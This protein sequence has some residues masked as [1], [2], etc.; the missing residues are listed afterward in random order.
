ML[1]YVVMFLLATT[2][3]LFGNNTKGLI[4]GDVSPAPKAA[5]A[6]DEDTDDTGEVDDDILIDDDNT[7]DD[8]DV[9]N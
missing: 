8:E 4:A 2:T 7:D 3:S 1:Q 6:A 9:Q 5:V